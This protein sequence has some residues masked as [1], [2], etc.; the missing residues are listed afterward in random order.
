MQCP[1]AFHISSDRM[2][3]QMKLSR[4]I[5]RPC[6][7]CLWIG[8]SLMSFALFLHPMNPRDFLALVVSAPF[9]TI[10]DTYGIQAAVLFWLSVALTMSGL[11]RV[12]WLIQKWVTSIIRARQNTMKSRFENLE[13]NW[14]FL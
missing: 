8:L 12:I 11:V 10:R 5:G 1:R 14:Y 2:E 7:Y 9:D 4:N 13:E 3:Y 6:G